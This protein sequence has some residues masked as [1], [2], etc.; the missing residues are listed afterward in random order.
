MKY[1]CSVCFMKNPSSIAFDTSPIIPLDTSKSNSIDYAVP[2][3]KTPEITIHPVDP[4]VFHLCRKCSFE[5]ESH[6]VLIS[7][8]QDEH[9][10][11]NCDVC[12]NSFENKTQLNTHKLKEHN[13]HKFNCNQC[14]EAFNTKA[15]L[16]KHKEKDHKNEIECPTCSEQF[17]NNSHLEE[18][19]TSTHSTKCP[20]CN[21]S[22]NGYETFADH[23]KNDHAPSCSQ[24]NIK[25]DLY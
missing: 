9:T 20:L 15:Q 11:V 14:E 1:Y 17:D 3:A 13:N 5:T 7:H 19:I 18:H 16:K 2:I 10:D 4:K 24:C 8:E 25:F 23:I 21:L 12:G 22:F 6:D